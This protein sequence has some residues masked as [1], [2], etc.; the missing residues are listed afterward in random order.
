MSRALNIIRRTRVRFPYIDRK[1]ICNV[2][3]EMRKC[4]ESKNYG[5]LKSL[6]E[7]AQI[8]AQA[9]EDAITFKGDI[10]SLIKAQKQARKLIKQYDKEINKKK[11]DMDKIKGI[12]K[13]MRDLS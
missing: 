9:M 6:I 5:P 3:E 7:Q 1:Y 11:P 13:E 4:D 10:T 12:L 8:M 2:L